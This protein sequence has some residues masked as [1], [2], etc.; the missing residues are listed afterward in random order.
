MVV[1]GYDLSLLYLLYII[2]DMLLLIDKP[3]GITSHD[4]VDK[5]R[6]ITGERKVGHGGTLDPN[7]TGL[8]IIGVTRK[9]TKQL[10]EYTKGKDKEYIAEVFLGEERDTGDVEGEV[11][12]RIPHMVRDSQIT[13]SLRD[14][15]SGLESLPDLSSVKE[16]LDIF[17]GEQEQKPPNHS[18]IKIKGKK[19]YEL[20]RA[21][22]SLSLG[23]R[24]ITIYSIELL[25]YDF[26]IL[27]IKSKVSSGT[28]IR[29]LARDIG[30]E[31]G[32]YGY[33]KELR[34]IK[35]GEI[36]IAEA[37]E[38]SDLNS[39]NWKNYTR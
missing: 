10:G 13:K 29:S 9:G 5:I 28:Y 2:I 4:V 15:K 18:A 25:E 21:G 37:V 24:N 23:P 17:V 22:K 35:V 34:R 39:V 31:L 7:A 36:D 38:L 12:A 14:D 11:V 32:T 27:K 16:V 3:K 8:L 33:L 30:R 26:P 19:A 1:A 6:K 20:A